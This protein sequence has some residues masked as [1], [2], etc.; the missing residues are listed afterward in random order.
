M[1]FGKKLDKFIWFWVYTLPF[2]IAGYMALANAG[3]TAGTTWDTFLAGF[4]SALPNA[5]T[6]Y[7]TISDILAYFLTECDFTAILAGYVSYI[8]VAH[9]MHIVELVLVF[10]VHVAEKLIDRAGGVEE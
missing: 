7:S 1:K 5:G 8:V 10:F 6:L 3:A 4:S 9:F 2:W